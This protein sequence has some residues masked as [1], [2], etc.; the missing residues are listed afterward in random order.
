MSALLLTRGGNRAPPNSVPRQW[1]GDAFHRRYKPAD[2]VALQ[3]ALCFVGFTGQIKQE[4]GKL[5][6]LSDEQAI[7]LES[8]HR[9]YRATE[10][11]AGRPDNRNRTELLVDE[12]GRFGHDEVGL[13]S[14]SVQRLGIA[15][16]LCLS[17]VGEGDARTGASRAVVHISERKRVAGLVLPGLE[18]H[19]LAGADTEQD[20]EHF[21]IRDLERERGIETAA[22]LLDEGEMEARGKGDRLQM[23]G[24]ALRVVAR[25]E[26]ALGVGVRPGNCRVAALVQ[27]GHRLHKCRAGIE[28]G[29][30]DA[31]ITRPEAGVDRKLCEVS[32]ASDLA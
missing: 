15:F 5:R 23:G 20:P 11:H 9:A 22:T 14:I 32:E 27:T 17:Q 12:V 24:E 6:R 18:V 28:V 19:D 21:Q 10:G 30:G 1:Y 25:E 13:Q 8:L 4:V 29:V 3:F 31:A 16:S 7:V 26:A 2:L